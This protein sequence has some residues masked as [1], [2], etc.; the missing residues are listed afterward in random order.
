MSAIAMHDKLAILF[1]VIANQQLLLALMIK[2]YSD[3]TL[4]VMLRFVPS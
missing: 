3:A 4:A 1:C 2:N